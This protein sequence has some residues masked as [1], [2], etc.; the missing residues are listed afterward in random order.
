MRETEAEARAKRQKAARESRLQESVAKDV[1]AVLA[2]PGKAFL[3][4]D[5]LKE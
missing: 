2:K 1:E 3:K 5:V 4:A